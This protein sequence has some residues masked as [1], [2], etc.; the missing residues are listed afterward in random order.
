MQIMKN[1]PR[2]SIVIPT[3]NQAKYL[4]AC[5]D[6]VLFQDYPNI[7]IVVVNDASTDG[8]REILEATGTYGGPYNAACLGVL[9]MVLQMAVIT[10][11]NRILGA[12]SSAITGI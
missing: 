3:Y 12:R 8:T 9:M 10:V 11:T 1:R 5:L 6:S 2:V 4:P 7:E